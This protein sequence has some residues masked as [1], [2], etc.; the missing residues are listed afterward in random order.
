MIQSFS[1]K[2]FLLGFSPTYNIK[3]FINQKSEERFLRLIQKQ[4]NL[5]ERVF[6]KHFTKFTR[7][8]PALKSSFVNFLTC[9]CNAVKKRMSFLVLFNEFCKI[10]QD[11]Y[12][13]DHQEMITFR[14]LRSVNFRGPS[15]RMYTNISNVLTTLPALYSRLL[16]YGLSPPCV[17]TFCV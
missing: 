16:L 9:A 7:K 1:I 15:H 14:S 13:V 10:F 6:L 4:T 17:H 8:K 2:L 5:Y 11:I 12:S 3:M